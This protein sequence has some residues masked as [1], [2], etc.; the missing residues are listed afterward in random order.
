MKKLNEKLQE[1]L[2]EN[3]LTEANTMQRKLFGI[4]SGA[5]CIIIAQRKWKN[6]NYRNQR[7]SAVGLWGEQSPRALLEKQSQGGDGRTFK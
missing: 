4:K 2:I 1:A 7:Y 3:G 5:D 6:N